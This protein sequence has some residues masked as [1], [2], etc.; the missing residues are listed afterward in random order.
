MSKELKVT[1]ARYPYAAIAAVFSTFLLAGCDGNSGNNVVSADQGMVSNKLVNEAI[2]ADEES[3]VAASLPLVSEAEP[4]NINEVFSEETK[5]QAKQE[6]GLETVGTLHLVSAPAEKSRPTVP[7]APPAAF[8]QCAICHSVKA[9]DASGVGPN[10]HGVYGGKAGAK[11]DY[12]YSP[13]MTNSG[14]QWT[15]V[16][17]AAYLADPKGVVPGTKMLVPGV[18]DASKLKDIIDYLE[19]IK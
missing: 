9:G 10:L 13:A 6:I 14:I 19:A 1:K 7:P 2:M 5:L 12:S 17:L 16:N 8:A 15:Q 18:A 3:K 11:S 4:A